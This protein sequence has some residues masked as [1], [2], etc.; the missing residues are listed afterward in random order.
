MSAKNVRAMLVFFWVTD[1]AFVVYWL[2]TFLELLPVE[3]LY[4]DYYNPNLVAWNLSFFPLDIL[5]SITGFA[6]LYA[7]RRGVHMW[8]P[9]AML[10]LVL[11]SCSG[12]QAIAFWAFKADFDWSWWIPNLYL[13]IYPLF[14]L[15][16]LMRELAKV[17]ERDS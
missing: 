4:Q 14:F 7:Y 9:L 17:R 1:V 13:L 3:Y 5:I 2:I 6:S 16:G 8:K 11:T 15:P 10:S 12:L